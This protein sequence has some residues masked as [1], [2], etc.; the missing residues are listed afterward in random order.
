MKVRSVSNRHNRLGI[1]L[2]YESA[3]HERIAAYL[4]DWEP[5]PYWGKIRGIQV[6]RSVVSRIIPR[7]LQEGV[8]SWLILYRT[9]LHHELLVLPFPDTESI[10][11]LDN[12]KTFGDYLSGLLEYI[13]SG[14][15]DWYPNNGFRNLIEYLKREKA[16]PF[17]HP[18][19]PKRFQVV[20]HDKSLEELL[21]K[22]G[23]HFSDE[24]QQDLV[25]VFARA[26]QR[27]QE[28]R[29]EFL[30]SLLT[31]KNEEQIQDLIR[32]FETALITESVQLADTLD[33]AVPGIIEKFESVI[34][35]ET[36]M[37]LISAETVAHFAGKHLVDDFDFSLCGCGLWKAV[38]RELNSSLIWHLRLGKGIAGEDHKPTGARSPK[39][40]TYQA[41]SETVNIDRRE[42]GSTDF[43]GITLGNI[44]YLLRS[45]QDNNIA[46]EL[47]PVLESKGD[48]FQFTFEANKSGL[49][50]LVG[51]VANIRNGHAHIR[52]MKE[53]SYQELHSLVLAP[54]D[55]PTESLLGKILAMKLAMVEYWRRH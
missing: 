12:P 19:P 11:V 6:S 41:G 44:K 8:E 10:S 47:R 31:A 43:E 50:Y 17:P 32:D 16:Y 34:D 36:R 25:P 42:R 46:E 13:Q 28:N 22:P 23:L 45:A 33:R 5:S 35:D 1:W 18:L 53:E 7:E 27:V 21:K 39:G 54:D 26:N 48:L 3:P 51:Q 9:N 2:Y 4:R 14:N 15:S 38:E 55:R 24:R 37:F 52:A 20:R 49:A 30:K 29:D 40:V